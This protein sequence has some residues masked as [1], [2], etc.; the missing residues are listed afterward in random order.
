MGK[1]I[2]KKHRLNRVNYDNSH[3]F[4]LLPILVVHKHNI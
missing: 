1:K 2:V 3:G 4:L